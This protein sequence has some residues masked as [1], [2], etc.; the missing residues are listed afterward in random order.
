M[1]K[2]IYFSKI[3]V[4]LLI[5]KNNVKLNTYISN[6]MK[7]YISFL[8]G[9]SLCFNP[10]SSVAFVSA[11]VKF[12]TERKLSSMCSTEAAADQQ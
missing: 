4:H 10:R 3:N 7:K 8:V 1:N 9:H 11:L 5:W 6:R 2:N 12:H